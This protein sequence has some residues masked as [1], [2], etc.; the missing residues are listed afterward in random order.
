M[1]DPDT[2][3]A[4]EALTHRLKVRD[5]ALRDGE[6]Y[7]DAEVFASEFLTALRGHGW[8]ITEAKVIPAWKVPAAKSDG[9]SEETRALL[10]QALENAEAAAERIRAAG[11]RQDGAA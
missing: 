10:R 4:V 2:A 1:T 11:T 6:D 9:P 3:A 7:A 5:K 8:R